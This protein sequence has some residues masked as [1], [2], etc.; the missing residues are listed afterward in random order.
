MKLYDVM[1]ATH[2]HKLENKELLH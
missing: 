2:L 1:N